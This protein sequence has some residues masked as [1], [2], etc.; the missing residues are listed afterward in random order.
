MP[1]LLRMQPAHVHET[2]GQPP[3]ENGSYLTRVLY[4]ADIV[5]KSFG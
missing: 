2:A 5:M 1:L 3:A 4:V